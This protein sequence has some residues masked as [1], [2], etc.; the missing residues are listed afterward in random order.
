MSH[1]L[2]QYP[3]AGTSPLLS[4]ATRK[5]HI[6]QALGRRPS[7]FLASPSIVDRAWRSYDGGAGVAHRDPG[8]AWLLFVRSAAES[9]SRACPLL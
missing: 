5:Q 2:L 6:E 1:L 8:A 7:L 9:A 4:S 3:N